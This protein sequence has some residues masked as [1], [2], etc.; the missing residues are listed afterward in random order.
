MSGTSSVILNGNQVLIPKNFFDVGV[1]AAFQDGNVQANLT[2]E[3]FT[4][5]LDGYQAVVDWINEGRTSGL[6][7][8][9]GIPLQIT[10]SDG[11]N[12][13]TI[14]NGILDLQ[15]GTTIFENLREL[16]API[17]QDNSIN[18]LAELIEPLDFGYLKELGVITSS[19][20]VNVDYV[21]NPTDNGLAT[22]TT[23]VTIY[24]LSKQLA[25]TIKEIGTTAA[26]ISG[27]TASGITGAVGAAIYAVAVAIL[28]IA[29]AAALLILII[30]FGQDLLNILVQPLRTHKAIPLKTLIEKTCEYIGYEFN[31]SIEDLDNLVYLPSN[32]NVD[33]YGEKNVLQQ[34]GEITEGIPNATDAGYTCTQLFEIL[35]D[36]FNARFAILGN[37]VEFH[38]EN[39]D[40]WIRQSSWEK[41]TSLK[42]VDRKPARY[43]TDEI[44]GS[45]LIQFETD[46]NDEYTINNYKGTSYQVL[47]DAKAVNNPK[48][49]TIKGLDAVRIPFALGN[50]KEQ[51]NFFEQA[52]VPLANLFD[53]I[54]DVFGRNPN[55][56]KKIKTKV[57]VLEVTNNNHTVPKLL[58][59]EG[60]RIPSNNRDVFSAK[61]LWDKYHNEKSFIQNNFGRQRRYV[62]GEIIPFGLSDFVT[63]LDNS[64][65]RDENGAS[66][67]IT[68]IEWNMSRDEATINY[69]LQEV[70]TTNLKETFIEPD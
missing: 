58:W 39:A 6:G 18:Q 40:F 30:D 42:D 10:H 29:Y 66:G 37:T 5:I 9:E 17:R 70:Y 34:P 50:R 28:Q 44:K 62:E 21:V 8:F 49:K 4:F 7:I 65:F 31:T 52:L 41:P 47:T 68:N 54:A 24:L 14:F 59:L 3:E 23:F 27:I 56:A 2:T 25:D 48:N 57:G 64:Y 45:I 69:W 19:D 63:L 46:I 26:T 22:I 16:T 43:N 20:Y 32:I 35:R 61:T 11:N 36:L 15:A 60:G 51:L 12:N 67:K 53:N 1:V 33:Q 13:T 38:T 55:L